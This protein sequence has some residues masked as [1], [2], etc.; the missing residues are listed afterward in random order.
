MRC[1]SAAAA[2]CTR[3]PTPTTGSNTSS[4]SWTGYARYDTSIHTPLPISYL[5]TTIPYKDEVALPPPSSIP[6][7]FLNSCPAPFFPHS[8]I[9]SLSHIH[10]WPAHGGCAGTP[11][12]S[13]DDGADRERHPH[14][15]AT[16]GQRPKGPAPFPTLPTVPI[17]TPHTLCIHTPPLS[18]YIQT[19]PSFSPLT[20]PPLLSQADQ[21]PEP[22]AAV[23]PAPAARAAE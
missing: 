19:P 11:R 23:H 7:P 2:S 22:P 1:S 6:S 9:I 12:G 3:P 21:A 5:P 18:I 15:Q 13:D 14:L 16:R 4:R 8:C 17:S 10:I 20:L